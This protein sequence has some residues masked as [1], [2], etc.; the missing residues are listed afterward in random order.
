M[1]FITKQNLN[2]DLKA[3]AAEKGYPCVS[4]IYPLQD[5]SADRKSDKLNIEESIKRISQQ[6]KEQYNN[7]AEE[8]ISTLNR[9]Y[10]EIDWS[11]NHEGIGLYAS[12]KIGYGTTFP[13]TVTRKV[14]VDEHF[15]LS[16]LL[17]KAQC[18][19]NYFVL[20]LDEKQARLFSGSLKEVHEIINTDFP[21]AYIND[22]EYM[23]PSRSTS[24]A[25]NAHEK[26][27]EK[28]KPTIDKMRYDAYLHKTDELLDQYLKDNKEVILCGVKR[29]TSAF[30]NRSSHDKNIIGMINGNYDWIN[31][32]DLSAMVWPAIN[33]YIKELSLEEI[34]QFE[35]KIGE[36]LFEEGIINVW[37]AIVDGRGMTLLLEKDYTITGYLSRQSPY[38][39][40]LKTPDEPHTILQNACNNL[41]HMALE[42]D[43]NIMLVENGLLR[44]H[45]KIALITRY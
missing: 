30:M 32:N 17:N 44:K 19:F 12:D 42:K 21:L 1:A 18:T 20:H 31:N 36:G 13:F 26:G 40:L 38:R 35:E 22:Y 8:L 39:L 25:G 7:K 16:N 14:V 29:S 2:E 34:S 33:D 15:E 5:L 23:P 11:R 37:E 9:L 45:Q 3:L 10:N 6:I 24:F 4:L 27:F 43:C 28:D 41:L